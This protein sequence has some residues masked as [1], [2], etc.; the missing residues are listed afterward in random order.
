MAVSLRV[1]IMGL[2]PGDQLQDD[3]FNHAGVLVLQKDA[4]LSNE[5]ITRLLQ[6]NIDF[7]DIKEREIKLG[8]LADTLSSNTAYHKINQQFQQAIHGFEEIF[9][10][11]LAD[12]SY[13]DNKVGEML[14]PMIGE[15]VE[16]KDV[17]SLLLLLHEGSPDDYTYS[18]SLQ[19]GMLSYYIAKWLD[20]SD[21]EA[22]LVSKAGYLSDIGKCKLPPHIV[23][24]PGKLTVEEFAEIKKHPQYSYNII[25][26]ST[27]DELTA[28]IALE[29][30]ERNDGSGYPKGLSSEEIHPYAKIVAVAD[31]YTAMISNR[32]YQ[33]KQTLLTV[34]KELNSLSFGKL[35]PEPTQALIKQMLPNF[36]GKKVLLSTGEVGVIIMT[37]QND[38]FRPLIQLESGFVNLARNPE[39]V[40]QEVYL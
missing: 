19:V 13:D 25:M 34:L 35:S 15:L 20:Y 7:V 3:T 24:K 4:M 31:V 23:N 6:H 17:V 32:V 22:Y 27:R 26:E 16:Q 2:V 37:N 1:H 38:F 36:I 30:H 8:K 39:L 29:H 40:I 18:H 28:R 10:S 14:Q 33:S 5:A 11:V 9:L 21:E 12:G